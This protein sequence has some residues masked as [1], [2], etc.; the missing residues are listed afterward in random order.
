VTWAS[1][2]SGWRAIVSMQLQAS[3]VW[4]SGGRGQSYWKSR[5]GR[6]ASQG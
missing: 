2:P 1:K 5:P 4:V 3:M 6:K